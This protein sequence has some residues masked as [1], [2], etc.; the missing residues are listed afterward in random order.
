MRLYP[1]FVLIGL[2]GSA[3]PALAFRIPAFARR[4]NMA[5]SACHT[6]IPRLN[7]VGYDYRN[8]G[9]RMPNE[10][11]DNRAIAIP[12]MIS[13]RT[14]TEA[15]WQRTRAANGTTSHKSQLNFVEFTAYPLSGSFGRYWSSLAELSF[16]SEDFWEIEN[17]YLRGT[18][19]KEENHFQ[20]RAGVF[21]PFEGYGASDRPAVLS[22]PLFQ[23]TPARNTGTS[24][25]FTPWGFDQVGVEAGYTFKNFSGAATLFNG[26]FVNPDERKAFPFQG[27]ELTRPSTDPNY[28]SKDFQLFA[29]QFLPIGKNDAA[30]SAFYY[31]GTL[32]VPFNFTSGDSYTDH[33][34]RLALYGTLPLALSK[35]TA[36]WVLG[37]MQWGRDDRINATTGSGVPGR[38]GSGGA[39]GELYVPLN[40]YLGTVARYDYFR[41]SHDQT[42]NATNAF[43]AGLNASALD[44][45]QGILEY[46][47]KRS[48]TGPSTS[49]NSH[50]LRARIILIL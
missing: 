16:S 25:F 4:E 8:A 13:A 37:G 39:F 23:T 48:E 2:A 43:T 6:S 40:R 46:Q 36:L 42:N 32:T 12:D 14:Q 35:T 27:G 18:F 7:R 11:G 30:I 10:I 26:I 47:F 1:L 31:S 21:H 5:C 19:G 22:R 33:F 44:G 34:D 9:Y 41:P 50:Q 28:D 24:T 15:G 29:N 38:F 45:V 17:A 3:S 20:V 49:T